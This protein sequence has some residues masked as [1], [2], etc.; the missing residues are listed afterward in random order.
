MRINKWFFSVVFIAALS[1]CDT[2]QEPIKIGVLHSLTGTMA[3]SERNLVDAVTLAVEEI[4]AQGGVLHRPLQTVIVDGKSDWQR[5]AQEADKLINEEQVSVIF[6]CWTSACRK[7]VKPVVESNDHLLFY[8]V[9]YE[10]VELSPNII[11]TGSVPNQQ[12]VPSLNWALDNLGQK[13]YLVGSD[14]VFPRTA[15]MIMKDML[16]TRGI[17]AVGEAYLPLGNVDIVSIIEDIKQLQ[18]DVIVNTINGDSNLAFFQALKLIDKKIPVLSFSIAEP[19]I[20]QIGIDLMKGHYASWS[21]FQSMPSVENKEFIKRFKQRFGEERLIND[22]MEAAYIGVKLWAQGVEAAATIAPKE[23]RKALNNQSIK[24]P[25]GIVTIDR[26]TGHLWKTVRIGQIQPDGQFEEI[27]TS[28]RPIR[29]VP[30]LSYLLESE[31]KSLLKEI[32]E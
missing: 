4:N 31:W 29:P 19:E 12:I 3:F 24:A 6:G 21:Y 27:W 20:K 2:K 25:E 1:S 23:V 13:V 26:E 8:P 9:Q 15:N 16:Q 17:N 28:G 22:P 10:G 11:Y 5:F 14:G 7:S 32:E 18:P 30:F